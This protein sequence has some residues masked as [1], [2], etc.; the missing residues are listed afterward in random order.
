[1]IG[2]KV[3]AVKSV[4]DVIYLLVQLLEVS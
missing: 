2:L 4:I 3:E 1:M